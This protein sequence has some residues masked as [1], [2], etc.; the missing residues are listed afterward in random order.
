MKKTLFWVLSLIFLLPLAGNAATEFKPG[1]LISDSEL[2]NYNS[3][4]AS[5]IQ[6]FLEKQN[7]YLATYTSTNAYGTTKSAAE[8][9]YEASAKNYDIF[10]NSKTGIYTCDDNTILGEKLIE[11]EV[12]S[13]CKSIT[14]VNPKFLLVLLQ[15]ETSLIE[16]SNP[17]SF[18]LD[19][20][21]G[22]MIYDGMITCS[23][24]DPCYRFKG[25]GK[26][27]NSAALQFRYYMLNPQK[28]NY[29]A[30]NT[31]T[32]KNQ[33]GT[34]SSAQ[35]EVYIENNATAALY[36]YT[37][38]VYNGNY[39]FWKLWNRYFP[40]QGYTEGT[41]LKIGS[42]YYLIQNGM[43]RKFASKSVLASRFDP[44]KAIEVS[45]SALNAYTEGA[46][47]KF[48]NY[49]II[50][51]PDGK[52]YL[53]VD[54]KKRMFAKDAF[55]ALG[56][57][58]EEIMT[59]SWQDV[60]SYADAKEITVA[61]AYATGALLQNKKT[62]GVYWVE[63]DSKAPLIDKIF[64]STKFKG[65]KITAVD[66]KVL[67]KFQTISPVKFNDGEI[68]K[69]ASSPSVFL[70]ENGQKRPF[71]SGEVFEGLGY[72]WSNIILVSDKILDL[73]TN[74]SAI[75]EVIEQ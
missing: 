63:D 65:K 7:S 11:S 55:K 8:I 44:N 4:S 28:Y 18:R 58:I 27:V 26:Q 13:K 42:D 34:I 35:T 5:Q 22:Y 53:L 17:S 56:Y 73:Y 67:E 43:S 52:L 60:N 37:P 9:I 59:A 41:I 29:K 16:N 30:G 51:A 19:F 21:T 74:G 25:F 68:L 64:L 69:S 45:A 46:P 6:N 32:F 62:G 71:I 75:S 49:S 66:E 24:Y 72:K 15:K 36:N 38:H 14:T 57:N 2:L 47:I 3:M 10:Y 33:Y 31:Y 23:P 39:N 50:M 48:S 12:A 70:I 54:G 61:T 20:A 40:T 1:F